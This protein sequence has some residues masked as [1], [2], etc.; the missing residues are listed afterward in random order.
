M[1]VKVTM[2]IVCLFVAPAFMLM[3]KFLQKLGL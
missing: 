3:V 1:S 2:F